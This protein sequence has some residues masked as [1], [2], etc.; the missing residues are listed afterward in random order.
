MMNEEKNTEEKKILEESNPTIQTKK[1][2]KIILIVV[3][4]LITVLG[5]FFATNNTMEQRIQKQLDLGYRYLTEMDYEQALVAFTKI[6]ELEPRNVEGYL[7]LVETYIAM[8]DFE[9]ALKHAKEGYEVTGD[10]RLKEKFVEKQLELGYQ[11]LEEMNYEKALTAFQEVLKLESKSA[12]SYLGL[13]ETYIAMGDFEMALKYAKEGYEVTGDVRLKEKIEMIESGNIFNYLGRTMKMTRYDA[14]GQI[15]YSH[16]YTYNL[17]GERESVTAFDGNGMQTGHVDLE[18]NEDGT[19]KFDYTYYTDI[20]ELLLIE[21]AYENG[22]KVKEIYYSGDN[23]S[24]IDFINMYEYNEN[25]QVVKT[26]TDNGKGVIYSIREYD[27]EGKLS[28]ES[29]YLA[30]KLDS[31]STFGEMISYFTFGEMI[32]GKETEQASYDAAGILE[33]YEVKELNEEGKEVYIE[34]DSEG[35]VISETIYE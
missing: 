25:N 14:E 31:Y 13:V 21:N 5:I 20:G 22:T 3:A 11:Y 2:K 10:A 1:S 33:W 23:R 18:Y 8:G 26:I 17:K 34:Y 28:K 15:M 30:N 32:N 4:I 16:Q 9:M 24:E 12:E 29:Y 7:G 27:L 19:K 35:N 6:L